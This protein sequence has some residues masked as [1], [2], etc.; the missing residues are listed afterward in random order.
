MKF[1][2]VEVVKNGNVFHAYIHNMGL[3][4]HSNSLGGVV[5]QTTSNVICYVRNSIH[6]MRKEK[7]P[8]E[9]F[10]KHFLADSPVSHDDM[11]EYASK[12]ENI[13]KDIN[14]RVSHIKI[15]VNLISEDSEELDLL[16]SSSLATA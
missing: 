4:C 16:A 5:Q 8:F 13:K 1:I 12:L 15:D 2:D 11:L 14:S 9:D 6:I 7:I 10:A 3:Y